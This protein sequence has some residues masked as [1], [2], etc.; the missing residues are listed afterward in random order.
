MSGKRDKCWR[1]AVDVRRKRSLS[2]MKAQFTTSAVSKERGE[3]LA[4]LIS[5]IASVVNGM[6]D[7]E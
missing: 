4:L 3:I 1:N 6:K 5:T 2:Y 7:N